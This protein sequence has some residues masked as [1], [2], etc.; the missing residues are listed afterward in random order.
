MAIQVL[1]VK[2]SKARVYGRLLAGIAGSIP[3]GA[4]ISVSCECY[5]FSRRGLCDGPITH[6]EEFYRLWC[7]IV[8]DIGTLRMRRAWRTLGSC[9]RE[10]ETEKRGDNSGDYDADM[11]T[12]MMMMIRAMIKINSIRFSSCLLAC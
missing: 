12:M 8:C 7:V 6:P 9:A 1:E 10:R 11:T 3:S 5:E 2:H 4:W